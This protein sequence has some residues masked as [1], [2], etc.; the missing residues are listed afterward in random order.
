MSGATSLSSSVRFTASI[1]DNM[2]EGGILLNR[3]F[4][5]LVW[6]QRI[7]Y[8]SGI[9]GEEI[10]GKNIYGFFPHL[11]TPKY[12]KRIEGIFEG[13]PSIVFSSQIHK[14]FIPCILSDKNIRIQHTVVSPLALA[15]YDYP[16]ALIAIQD[17]TEDY[18]RIQKIKERSRALAISE[19]S[20]RA[21][22]E[23]MTD[24]LVT[25]NEKGIIQS[26]NLAAEKLFGYECS[27]VIGKNISLL[28]PE[29]YKSEHDGYIENYFRTGNPKII[30]FVRELQGLK[31]DG[32]TFHLELS[33]GE[34][35]TEDEQG[36][37]TLTFIGSCKNIEG[38]KKS[39]FELI[40]LFDQNQMILNAAREGIFGIDKQ[41]IT[42]FINPAGACLLGYKV[43]ELVG[44]SI[45]ELIH[46]TK[47]DGRLRPK[48]ESLLS[49][50]Y[51]EDKT[52]HSENELFWR[53]DGT[54]FPVELT[55]SPIKEDDK[56]V[57]SVVTFK[58]ITARKESEQS[59]LKAKKEAEKANNAK[60]EFLSSMSHELRTPLNAIL[61]FSQLLK[62]KP[63]SMSALQLEHVQRITQ[64]GEHLLELINEVLDLARIESDKINLSLEPLKIGKLLDELMPLVKPLVKDKNIEIK[65]LK[66]E[67][68]E[69]RVL[70]DRVRFK[71]VF[72]N[73]VSNAIKYN[74]EQ[75]KVEISL[76]SAADNYLRIS[77]SDQGKGIPEDQRGNVFEAFNRLK[78]DN[79][80][81]G[82]GIGLT[83][84]QK[85]VELMNGRIDFESVLGEGSCFYVEFPITAAN[86]NM[87]AE[88]AIKNLETIQTDLHS[89]AKDFNIL[90]IE[91]NSDNVELVR[92][93]LMARG[94]IKLV[95]YSSARQGIEF[96][97]KHQP[98]LILMDINLPEM[99][100][101]EACI[102]LKDNSTTA[103]IPVI[104]LSANAMEKN[105]N[106]ALNAGF[107]DYLTK[108][109]DID[110]LINTINKF[111]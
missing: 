81:E 91:D 4:E 104:A 15:G 23:N 46:H 7:A 40:K 51:A 80:V 64:S 19:Q 57:G 16:L 32:S 74:R 60:S 22:T 61:G 36:N 96:A 85:L 56:I 18:Y 48:E 25:I 109:I 95:S 71:Q 88:A 2:Q 20:N 84:T 39:E 89:S 111:L 67:F 65:Y 1:L 97:L 37:P 72:L 21:I 108:P 68:S 8:W 27:E 29:P 90:Y 52:V 44:T 82:T 76:T 83:I 12:C 54:G 94:N 73:L 10:I 47:A 106:E 58:D 41:G 3:E 42:T 98:D 13:S 101:I 66:N 14:Y 103:N 31:K 43:D 28:M 70:V 86:I 102:R 6:N 110:L 53:K 35:R 11:K 50:E 75:G 17:V 55:I 100:G 107:K 87:A 69:L 79:Q 63:Q 38:R 49:C 26:F 59:L 62:L 78:E 45:H 77:V 9:A 34:F 33:V 5:V 105:I 24:G 92:Q 93:I 99:N 30:G